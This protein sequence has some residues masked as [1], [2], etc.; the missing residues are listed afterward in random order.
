MFPRERLPEGA[1]GDEGTR[2]FSAVRRTRVEGRRTE[3]PSHV[4]RAPPCC[5]SVIREGF[6]G[7]DFN[8]YWQIGGSKS[9]LAGRIVA[10]F[11]SHAAKRSALASRHRH[12]EPSLSP[13]TSGLQADGD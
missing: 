8:N 9:G 4:T 3:T 11:E 2:S 1:E 13:F 6:G 12:P 7:G 10:G 5:P